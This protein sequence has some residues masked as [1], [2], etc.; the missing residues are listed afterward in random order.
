MAA[1]PWPGGRESVGRAGAEGGPE[2][3]IHLPAPTFWPLVAAVGLGLA[4]S[5][6]LASPL[7]VALGGLIG[8][9]GIVGWTWPG[10]DGEREGE[11]LSHSLA[12]SLSH[13]PGRWGM[14]LLI[15]AEATL[16][17]Y[18]LASYFYLRLGAASWPPAGIERPELQVP[19]INTA[20]LLSSSLPMYW[21]DAAIRRGGQGRLMLGLALSFG[22][23][24]IF[25]GLQFSEYGRLTFAPQTN[26]YGSLFFT[27]TGFHGAHVLAGLLLNGLIQVRAWLG[28]FDARRH[29]AVET[30]ALYWHFVDVVWIFI[31][32]SL[33]LSP[34]L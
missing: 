30:A 13:S 32:V 6:P 24:A 27:V 20:I 19:A 7:L 2:A 8:F 21:A 16:F 10:G 25:L 18:L 9:V 33:Y 26:A 12:P 4:F 1:V 28:H 23:G 11:G 14:V 22:L 5:C 29:L 17:L 15:A 3:A 31:F 34:H